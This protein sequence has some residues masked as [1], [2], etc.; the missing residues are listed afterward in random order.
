MVCVIYSDEFLNH[1]TGPAHP[2]SPLRL[3]AVTRYLK[4]QSH[5]RSLQWRS[6]NPPCPDLV[7][8]VISRAH[9]LDYVAQ[10]EKLAKQGGGALDADTPVSPCSYNV[11]LLAVQAWLDGLD[12]VYQRSRKGQRLNKQK[13][14]N[15]KQAHH[16]KHNERESKEDPQLRPYAFVLARPPGHHACRQRGMGFCLFSNA[17]IAALKGL[18]LLG[19]DRVAIVDWDVHHGNGTQDIVQN[20]RAIAYCSIHQSPAYPGTGVPSPQDAEQELGNHV[21]NIPVA[22]GTDFAAYRK[23]WAINILPFL[24]DFEPDLLIVSAGYDA[25]AADPLAALLLTPE[26]YQW[27]SDSL[28]SLSC[29]IVFGLEGGYDVETLAQ[30]VDYTLRPLLRI[31]S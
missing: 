26:N 7:T 3:R 12:Y 8:T 17:A 13:L 2:E 25:T 9:S 22:P 4:G 29:P 18:T 15:Q 11:G 24:R 20:H 21:L 6:P 28:L 23:V 10:V 5:L 1:D 30:C 27:L 14:D 31:V 16:Q 19:I